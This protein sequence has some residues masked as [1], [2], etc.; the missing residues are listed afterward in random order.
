ML[1][2]V[3]AMAMS[4][5]AGFISFLPSHVLNRLSY[6][7]EDIDTTKSVRPL[8]SFCYSSIDWMSFHGSFVRF[9]EDPEMQVDHAI[10]IH[11]TLRLLGNNLIQ[12]MR[13]D[14]IFDEPN[15]LAKVRHQF[16]MRSVFVHQAQQRLLSLKE[17]Y[18]QRQKKMLKKQRRF[19]LQFVG[20]H[21]RRTD[22]PVGIVKAY[23]LPELDPSYYLRAI[24]AYMTKYKNVLFVMVSDDIEWVKQMIIKRLPKAPLFVGGSGIPDDDDE[25]GLDFAL[26]TQ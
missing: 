19:P 4:D 13:W 7:F 21:V 2:Y 26:L 10:E 5:R 24:D 1:S 3:M 18:Y 25:I 12:N 23:K 22:G 16:T 14:V 6:F 17:A 20:V 9:M 11:K 15:L 8:E